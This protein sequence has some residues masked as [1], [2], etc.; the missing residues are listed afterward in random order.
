[1]TRTSFTLETI[2][3]SAIKQIEDLRCSSK[4]TQA[5]FEMVKQTTTP[6]QFLDAIKKQ[7]KADNSLLVSRSKITEAIQPLLLQLERFGSAIDV[8][9][10]SSPQIVGVNLVGLIWGSLRL[11]IVVCWNHR[12]TIWTEPPRADR[13]S[14]IW[15]DLCS[16]YCSS[17]RNF[18]SSFSCLS[19]SC[20]SYIYR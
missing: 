6:Q 17:S 14:D 10:Q 8:L 13:N 5:E 11:L 15:L 3:A 19:W 20:T 1:M 7:T 4:I 16:F 2:Y 12:T 18:S 9:A